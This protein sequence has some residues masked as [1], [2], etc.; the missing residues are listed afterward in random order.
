MKKIYFKIALMFVLTSVWFA[1]VCCADSL[2]G[3]GHLV[4]LACLVL[5]PLVG[6]AWSCASG[7][8]DDLLVLIEDIEK[9]L[10]WFIRHWVIFC[11]FVF[12]RSWWVAEHF[13]MYGGYSSWW[14][15]VKNFYNLIEIK[16]RILLLDFCFSFRMIISL[17]LSSGFYW[18]ISVLNL[19]T[20][21]CFYGTSMDMML[22]LIENWIC[23]L[24]SMRLVFVFY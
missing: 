6:F 8:I 2:I 10:V 17:R 20:H 19:D 13:F 24:I 18:G 14:N 21:Y 12:G 1:G 5:L 7:Y 3:G 23:L 4:L 15:D 22:N 11:V 16:L 9:R